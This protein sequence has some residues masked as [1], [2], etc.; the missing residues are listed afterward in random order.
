[1]QSSVTAHSDVMNKIDTYM[2]IFVLSYDGQSNSV[3]KYLLAFCP[4]LPQL[5][6]PEHTN[7]VKV[8]CAHGTYMTVSEPSDKLAPS[9]L[10]TGSVYPVSIS[11]VKCTASRESL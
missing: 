7:I 1:M 2:T 3:N 11:S 8:L 9:F 5:W 4:F 6:V 10:N